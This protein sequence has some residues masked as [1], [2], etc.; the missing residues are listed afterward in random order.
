MWLAQYFSEVSQKIPILK[1]KTCSKKLLRSQLDWNNDFFQY[2]NHSCFKFDTCAMILIQYTHYDPNPR[3]LLPSLFHAPILLLA[4]LQSSSPLRTQMLTSV[5]FANRLINYKDTKT[6]WRRQKKLTWKGT[7]RQVFIR[8][9]GLEI[10]SVMSV[11]ST[12]LC[13]LLPQMNTCSKVPLQVSCFRWRHF[14]L[15]SMSLIFY[16]FAQCSLVFTPSLL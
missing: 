5:R 12:Q 9:Y 14:A 15:L 16:G 13:E 7:L 6:K 1:K 3:T 11:F 4:L 8:V 10:Q 2:L